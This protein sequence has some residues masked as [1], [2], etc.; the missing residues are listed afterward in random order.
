MVGAD[1]AKDRID[2]VGINRARTSPHVGVEA[3][4]GR[5]VYNAKSF[6]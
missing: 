1:L 3:V 4:E 6:W 5:S 2:V